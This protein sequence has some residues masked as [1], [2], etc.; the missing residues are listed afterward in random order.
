MAEMATYIGVTPRT[1]VCNVAI[2]RGLRAVYGANGQLTLA[3]ATVRGDYVLMVDGE[4]ICGRFTQPASG[5]G[6][7]TEV[8]IENVF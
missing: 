6:V 7:L 4:A 2:G 1:E 8:E 5:A 3:G